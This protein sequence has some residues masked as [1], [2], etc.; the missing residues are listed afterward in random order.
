MNLKLRNYEGRRQ[1]LKAQD[2]LGHS[3]PDRGPDQRIVTASV[4]FGRDAAHEA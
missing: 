1:D 3:I 4:Q 2:P